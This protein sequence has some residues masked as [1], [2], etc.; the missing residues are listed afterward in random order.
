MITCTTDSFDN[1]KFLQDHFTNQSMNIIFTPTERDTFARCMEITNGLG[2][3]LILDFSGSMVQMKRQ[4]LKLSS[5]YGVIAT[6]YQDMQLDP[7]ES[8][9]L[10]QK[11]VTLTFINFGTMLE[12]GLFDGV[13]KTLFTDLHRKLIKNEFGHVMS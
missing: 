4:C 1:Q 13:T 9:F 6:T 10:N 3:D 7:P 5:F 2:Y 11:C 8:K 12:S